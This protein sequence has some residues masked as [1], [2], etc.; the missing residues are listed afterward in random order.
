MHPL[1][2]RGPH[3]LREDEVRLLVPALSSS[4]LQ[5]TLAYRNAP[6]LSD[7]MM[8]ASHSAQSR[9]FTIAI[10]VLCLVLL[11]SAAVE[12]SGYCDRFRVGRQSSSIR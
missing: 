11:S 10:Q 7:G 4:A 3:L 6:L 12:S 5:F 9:C 1:P 8:A 2:T